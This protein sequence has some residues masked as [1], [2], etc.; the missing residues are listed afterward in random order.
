MQILPDAIYFLNDFYSVP[1]ELHART[2]T[3]K[4]QNL[5]RIERTAADDDFLL[6]IHPPHFAVLHELYRDCPITIED[7][8]LR[9]RI[10][11]DPDVGP[12]EHRVDIAALHSG[13]PAILDRK[14]IDP[15]PFLGIAIEII[16]LWITK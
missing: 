6:D 2:N 10:Y 9:A 15:D 11:F 4:H 16:V 8:P 12:D 13:P 5:G 7:D 1:I 14:L 3:R